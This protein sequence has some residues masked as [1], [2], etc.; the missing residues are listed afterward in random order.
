MTY[1]N[2]LWLPVKGWEGYYSISNHGRFRSEPRTIVT[3]DGHKRLVKGGI[4][5]MNAKTNGYYISNLKRNDK[6]HTIKTHILVAKAFIDN[7]LGKPFIN[8]KD[9]NKLN[10]HI[11][12]LEWCTHL[13]NVHHAIATGLTK[14]NGEDSVLSKLTEQD[15]RRIQSLRK[16]GL[17]LKK[18]AAIINKCHW[19][20]IGLVLQGK[21]WKHMTDDE[22]PEEKV[23]WVCYECRDAVDK[24]TCGGRIVVNKDILPPHSQPSNDMDNH[25]MNIL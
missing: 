9:G 2:E 20:Y 3:I 11:D 8:H 14:Q 15:V 1:E 4:S 24:C 17:T 10:N 19:G 18:I 5:K 21:R 6:G 25:S 7:P 22:Q 13:E 23:E 16:D 12:N